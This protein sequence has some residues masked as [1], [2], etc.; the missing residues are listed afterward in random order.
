MRRTIGVVI[1]VLLS[2]I[3]AVISVS[4]F[5]ATD[6]PFPRDA[7]VLIATFGVGMAVLAAGI[8]VGPFR[9][10]ERW[11]I[12]LLAVWPAFFLVHILALGTWLPDGVFLVISLVALALGGGQDKVGTT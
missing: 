8:A 9:R 1:L 5:F 12:A 6:E 3:T 11:A 10:G 7:N 4:V 2:L